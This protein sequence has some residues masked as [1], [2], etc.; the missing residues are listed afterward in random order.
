M[1]GQACVFY[2]AAEFSRDTDF[3]IL[4]SAAN[5]QRLTKALSEL[6]AELIA[7][8]SLDLNHLH[9]GHAVHFR[10]HHPDAAGLRVDVMTKMRGVDSFAKLWARRTTF[11]MPDGSA[12][13]LLALPDLVQAKKTQRDKD[14][15]MLRRL[16]E[17]HY[18]ANRVRPRTAQIHFWF[19]ELRTAELLMTLTQQFRSMAQRFVKTRPLLRSALDGDSAALESG[20]LTEEL[21]ER[22]ADRIYWKPLRAELESMR[23]AKRR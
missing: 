2:G 18:F 1:G 19:S 22:E 3:A 14:W 9:K 13:D 4:A 10:C 12:C 23:H 11:T 7:V 6:R 5:L 8:P 21:L 17:A 16:V 15:P 20:L